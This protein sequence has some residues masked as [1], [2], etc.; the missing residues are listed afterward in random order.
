MNKIQLCDYGCG[1]EAKHQF[2]N[3]KWCCSNNISSCPLV[4]KKKSKSMKGKNTQSPSKETRKKQSI[5]MKGKNKGSRSEESKRKQSESMK[6]KNTGPCSEETKRKMSKAKIG[7]KI[8]PQSKEHKKKI[9]ESRK[10][11]LKDYKEKYPFFSKIEE[12]RYNP[13]KIEEKEIQVHCKN[14][15]CENSKEKGGWFTP[16]SKQFKY[17]KDNLENEGLD[18][19]YFYCS[20]HCKDTCPLY[21][22]H[23]D[24]FKNTELPYTY[25]EYKVC[26]GIVLER[27]SG[28]C[29][30]C[31]EPATHI[32]HIFPVKLE[33]FFALDPDCCVACCEK[34]HYKYAHKDK[35]STGNLAKIVCST[36][37]QKFLK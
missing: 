36:E 10:F 9:S 1:Q 29:E 32:H 26:R 18:R 2:K 30:Y 22:L 3:G 13:D 20:Q 12:M 6:G 23:G 24:P 15:E 27:E 4:R 17:R 11:S 5:S 8:G 28:L 7:K 19:S 21:N 31:G 25:Q 37:S 34:C 35:C 33:P 14:H 16:T